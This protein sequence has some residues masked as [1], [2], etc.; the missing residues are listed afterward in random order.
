[1]I[2]ALNH[3]NIRPDPCGPG[4]RAGTGV[5]RWRHARRSD[6]ARA[7]GRDDVL[8]LAQQMASAL[9][10]AHN[11][12]RA[13]G[14][15]AGERQGQGRRHGQGSGFRT[16][17]ADRV[18]ESAPPTSRVARF[19]RADLAGRSAPVPEAALAPGPTHQ[20]PIATEHGLSSARPV[21]CRRSRR[22]DGRST[23]ARTSGHSASFDRDA[24]RPPA[25]RRCDHRRHHLGGHLCA[26]DLGSVPP[27]LRPLLGRCL[28]KDPR[29]RLRDIGDA[30]SLVDNETALDT[31]RPT[32][33]PWLWPAS[34]AIVAVAAAAG[35]WLGRGG[36][37][38]SAPASDS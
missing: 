4:Q 30:M 36:V 16:G 10:A 31:L 12:G 35:F 27:E 26:P 38:P 20:L 23:S 7:A 19:R 1:M 11:A 37:A 5:G 29:R 18:A 25:V 21:T 14:L 34:M 3:P 9:E 32:P 33:T 28:E 13:S 17:E 8:A 2:A 22:K 6:R 24:H 15:Q